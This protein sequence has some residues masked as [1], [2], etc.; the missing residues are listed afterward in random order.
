MFYIIKLL[1]CVIGSQNTLVAV[2]EPATL[3]HLPRLLAVYIEH[4]VIDFV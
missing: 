3:Q 2:I 4:T 1:F